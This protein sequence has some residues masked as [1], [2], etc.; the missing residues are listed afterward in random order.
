M[1][2]SLS[3]KCPIFSDDSNKEHHSNGSDIQ[4]SYKE[5]NYILVGSPIGAG[6]DDDGI[7]KWKAE[8]DK[9]DFQ[10]DVESQDNVEFFVIKMVGPCKQETALIEISVYVNS[11]TPATKEYYRY[12]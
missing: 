3:Y 12:P 1:G 8:F 7:L 5:T 6:I 4:Q 11:V 9:H 10:H 2:E